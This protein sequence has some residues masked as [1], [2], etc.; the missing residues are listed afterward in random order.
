MMDESSP[1]RAV[2]AQG[3][4]AERADSKALAS[5]LRAAVDYRGDV[6]LTRTDGSSVTGYIFDLAEGENEADSIVKL[7]PPDGGKKSIPLRDIASIEF[8]GKDTAEGRSFET[9]V[10]KYVQKK[11]AGEKASIDS[12]PLA[13]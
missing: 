11:L 5:A 4:R 8:T 12:E 3:L 1:A 10:R 13:E 2:A 9:W 7:F 6:T